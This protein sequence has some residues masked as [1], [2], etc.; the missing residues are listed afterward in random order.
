[1][2]AHCNGGGER[3]CSLAEAGIGV[4]RLMF[5]RR[6]FE[7]SFS[8]CLIYLV[9]VTALFLRTQI[10]KSK[11]YGRRAMPRG[12]SGLRPTLH[13]LFVSKPGD[14]ITRA[15]SYAARLLFLIY[16]AMFAFEVW[17]RL[18]PPAH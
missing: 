8:V 16:I 2:T 13:V 1:M 12:P 7:F 6:L 11:I 4:E 18:S 10:V 15:L 9:V 3:Q 5:D 14:P 17:L